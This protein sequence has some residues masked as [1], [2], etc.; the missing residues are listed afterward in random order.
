MLNGS[1]PYKIG[2]SIKIQNKSGTIRFVGKTGFAPGIWV[3]IELDQPEGVHNGKLYG[4]RYFNCNKQHGIFVRSNSQVLIQSDSK[5]KTKRKKKKKKK[6]KVSMQQEIVLNQK[7]PLSSATVFSPQT[8]RMDVTNKRELIKRIAFKRYIISQYSK[9]KDQIKTTIKK[10]EKL[11]LKKGKKGKKLTNSL[12]QKNKIFALKQRI[13]DLKEKER[14][15]QKTRIKTENILENCKEELESRSEDALRKRFLE[16]ELQRKILKQKIEHTTE[17]KIKLEEKHKLTHHGFTNLMEKVK[18]EKDEVSKI[19]QIR[20]GEIKQIEKEKKEILKT[21]GNLVS[22]TGMN[23]FQLADRINTLNKS[24][25]S[26]KK[27]IF[28][29]E[30]SRNR[31]NKK[32][33]HI[34]Q[35]NKNRKSQ[36]I[37][38]LMSNRPEIFEYREKLTPI[39]NNQSFGRMKTTV[40]VLKRNIL[41]SED[42]LQLI[43]Q[44]YEIEKLSSIREFIEKR[45]GIK[46]IFQEQ[47]ESVL[48]SFLKIGCKED[49]PLW[50]LI[51]QQ[52]D[53]SLE[54]NQEDELNARR[55][56][57]LSL[58]DDDTNIWDEPTN[59]PKNIRIEN[60]DIENYQNGDFFS[61]IYL[62]NINKLIEHLIH[63]IHFDKKYTETFLMTH[64][65]FLKSEHLFLKIIQRYRVPPFTNKRKRITQGKGNDKEK[66]KEKDEK[67]MEKKYHEMKISIQKNAIEVLG[68]WINNQFS[69]F[70][71]ILIE[72]LIAFIENEVKQNYHKESQMLIQNI[73]TLQ[74]N[75]HHTNN[76]D[77]QNVKKVQPPA[78]VIPKSLFSVNFK[79]SDVKPI[80]MARQI[81]L[82]FQ[83]LFNRIQP[84]DVIEHAYHTKKNTHKT[85]NIEKMIDKFN[86]FSLY[87][88]EQIV[89]QKTLRQRAAQFVRWIKIGEFIREMNNFD[90]LLM[91]VGGMSN[92]SCKRLKVTKSEVSKNYWKS[93]DNFKKDVTNLEGY[94]NY[95]K[96]I[97]TC[98]LPALPYFGVFKKDLV[99][100]SDGSPSTIEGL[101][102]FRKRKFVYNI[103]RQIRKFQKVR[104]NFISIFQIQKLFKLKLCNKNSKQLFEISLQNEPRG[105]TRTS[106]H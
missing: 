47:P 93:F 85:Q 82:F 54:V 58:D 105:S 49:N 103:V 32:R 28:V 15:S 8:K 17:K 79:L 45:T 65:D 7:E 69:D 13:K 73:Q 68:M 39:L 75:K 72:Q 70:G 97:S 22:K 31:Q 67:E 9:E 25:S 95:R 62:L 78:P 84:S 106:L 43:M 59:N 56:I 24:I 74:E 18:A 102:N 10:K 35:E 20:T 19:Y 29:L 76:S 14:A 1:T 61:S 63:P 4:Q 104:Y 51:Q 94:K 57:V 5:K 23:I 2:D 81:T 52:E 11:L 99:Y 91:I 44:H 6:E 71:P 30:N 87:L 21:Y 12:N 66:Q 90:S 38:K 26:G 80:E 46:Y 50:D 37:S 86:D 89:S 92:S 53:D 83:Q 27:K 98:E 55:N 42:I 3:G 77:L 34:E 41:N 101:I 96:L 48:V 33:S 16:L 36:W 100:I 64:H 60:Q 88:T 40:K